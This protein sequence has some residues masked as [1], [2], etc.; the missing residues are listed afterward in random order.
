MLIRGL[1]RAG[2][3]LADQALSSLTNFALGVFVARTVGIEEFG[4][5][6]LVFA[7]YLLVMS[8]CREFPMEPLQI[9]YSGTPDNVIRAAA[10]RAVRSVLAIGIATLVILL[11]ISLVLGGRIGGTL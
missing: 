5:F 7:V 8:V 2:W 4:A 9:R 6:S 11:P 10:R 1:S 3:G